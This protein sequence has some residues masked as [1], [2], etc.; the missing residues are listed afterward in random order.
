[1]NEGFTGFVLSPLQSIWQA[2]A[3]FIPTLIGALAVLIIG[4]IVAGGVRAIIQ[5]IFEIVKLDNLLKSL[6]VESYFKRAGIELRASWFLGQVA[7]WFLVVSFLLAAADILGLSGLAAFL[8]DVLNYL[9]NI[10]VAALV[11]LATVV[12]GNFLRGVVRAS[13]KSARLP[14]SHFVSALVW[15]TVVLFG[16][17]AALAQL[18]IATAIVQSVITGFIAMLAL[19]G[20]LAFG[21]GGKE[22][23]GHLVEKLREHTGSR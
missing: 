4:L 7:F 20:G 14:A 5:K 1:M 23:A 12:V 2:S 16:F 6:G 17:F 8:T 18:G 22:Y 13:A 3:A 10:F 21:L 15:W 9:P 19:A 11:M